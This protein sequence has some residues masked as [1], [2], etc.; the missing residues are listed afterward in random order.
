MGEKR[1][2]FDYAIENDSTLYG[3]KIGY[4]PQYHTCSPGHILLL[5]IL[6]QACLNQSKEYDFLGVDDE[7]KFSFTRDARRHQWL[8]LFPDRLRPKLLHAAKFHLIP[9]VKKICT[10]Q[11]GQA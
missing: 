11:R 8:F 6:Q 5:L 7:W 2:A 4:D 1:I 10:F 3:I 9:R